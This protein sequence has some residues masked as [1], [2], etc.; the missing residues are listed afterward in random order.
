MSNGLITTTSR[1]SVSETLARLRAALKQ[2]ELTM[3]AQ[4]DHAAGAASVGLVLRPTTVV[5]FG[6]PKG[7]TPLMQEAQTVGIDLPLKML[8]WEDG[9]GRVQLSYN[10]VAWIAQRHG[11]GAAGAPAVAALNAAL[12]AIAREVTA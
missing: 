1:H 8:V 4:I 9:F 12:A 5:I 3:F 2:R 6:N 10:D 7:G 11:L